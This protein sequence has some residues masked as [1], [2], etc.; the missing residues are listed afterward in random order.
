VLVTRSNQ[1]WLQ[2][3]TTGIGGILVYDHRG[4]ISDHSDD[5]IAHLNINP[6]SGALPSNEVVSMAEDKDG[7]IWVGTD[8]GV[9]VFYNP[10]NIF[11]SESFDAQSIL[12]NQDGHT[13]KLL[14]T[15]TVTAISIDGAN[16]KWFGTQNSGVYLMSGDGTKELEH[17]SIDNSPLLSNTILALEVNP[18]TGEV[19]IATEKGLISY[20]GTSTIGE[21]KCEDTYAYP[22]PVKPGYSGYIAVRGLVTDAHV[23]ITD[24]AGNM[25][26]ETKAIGGQAI[27][28]GKNFNGERVHSGVYIVFAA[29]EDA[30]ETCVTKILFVN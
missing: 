26:F 10:A 6:G 19:F 2:V 27:W 25:V 15:E 17:F 22:N 30:S 14:E 8:K 23:R 21:T 4:T 29:N 7:S 9:V 18:V 11:T 20:K 24:I 28:D 1:I 13:Q 16:R 12:I 3:R 5:R